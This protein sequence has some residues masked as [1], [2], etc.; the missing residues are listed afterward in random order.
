MSAT[1]P[2]PWRAPTSRSFT[3]ASKKPSPGA[4]LTVWAPR[5][6]PLNV[7][8]DAGAADVTSA[9]VNRASVYQRLGR[10]APAAGDGRRKTHLVALREAIGLEP[11]CSVDIPAGKLPESDARPNRDEIVALAVAARRNY[12]SR[13]LRSGR[14]PGNRSA[15]NERTPEDADVCRRNGHPRAASPARRPQQRI[16]P[17]GRS[18]GDARPFGRQSLGRVQHARALHD[19]ANAVAAT[20]RNLIAL[21]AEDAFLRWEEASQE[22]V[23]A[24]AAA[25]AGDKLASDQNRDFIAGLKVKVDEVVNSQ[26]LAAQMRSQYNEYLYRQVLCFADLE[27]VTAGGFCADW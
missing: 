14:L 5:A 18:A 15:R 10:D 7:R 17:C 13:R 4:S 25:D 20:T 3:P 16:P 11:E 24:R 21:E 8:I 27:R 6:T 1:R 19:R 2:T 26:V 12:P 22:V 9:D 23:A